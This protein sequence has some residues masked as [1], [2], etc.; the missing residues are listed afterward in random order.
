MTEAELSHV[1]L[2]RERGWDGTVIALGRPEIEVRTA[3]R[4]QT[5]IP[6]PFGSEA[7]R[8]A[9]G[10]LSRSDTSDEH[11]RAKHFVVAEPARRWIR[12]A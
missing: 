12:Q 2:I 7:L 4:I 1:E 3:L 8:K 5:V 11:E 6:R 10:E 9:V